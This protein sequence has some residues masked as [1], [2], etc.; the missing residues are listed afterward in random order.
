MLSRFV[1]PASVSAV[2]EE[3]QTLCLGG[4]L[5]SSLG[6]CNHLEGHLNRH[7][8]VELHGSLVGANLLNVLDG[9]DLAIYIE[10]EG[11]KSLGDVQAVDRR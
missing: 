6:L 11:C 4:S 5:G 8:L 3:A 2:Q 9:D 1:I 7:L 10:T